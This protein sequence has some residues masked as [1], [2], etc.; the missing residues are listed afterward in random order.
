MPR[1]SAFAA[2][3]LVPAVAVALAGCSGSPS[4]SATST[5]TPNPSSTAAA[6]TQSSCAAPSAGTASKSVK[7]TGKLDAAPTVKFDKGLSVTSTQ[8]STVIEGS[9]EKALTGTLLDVAFT[10]YDAETGKKI[11]TAGYSGS[12]ATQFTVSKDLYLAGLVDGM[13]CAQVGSRTV[14]V[15]DS[16][17]MFG[18]TGNESLG[19]AAGDDMVIVMDILSKV[20][21]K[22]T[23]T[24]VAPKSGFPAVKLAADGKP[25]VTIPKTTA[26]KSL[27]LEVLKKGDGATVKSGATVT[28]QYQGT[29]WR[30]GEVFDQ[31]WGSGP[32][33]FSTDKVVAGFKKAIV[34]QTIGSQVVVIVPPS[35]GYGSAGN[36][37]A[38][39]KGTDTLVFV[40]DILAQG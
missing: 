28:V 32:T 24:T 1:L 10:I 33:S 20:P 5:S 7:V 22:A 40:V 36:T 13:H 39:I 11:S 18:T 2:L 8:R 19:V 26:P 34:G 21:T 38:G 25:T 9:G 17:D 29:L 31:S 23:G 37:T 6:E 35:E 15:A 4:T 30:T 16:A 12:A 3:A 27:K 14:T